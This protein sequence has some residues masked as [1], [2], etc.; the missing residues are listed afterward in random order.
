MKNVSLI[1]NVVLAVAVAV[2]FYFHFADCAKRNGSHTN[3]VADSASPGSFKIA[4]FDMDTLE[5]KY[6][7]LKE[8]RAT[9]HQKDEANTRVLT[10]MR[11][12]LA[13]KYQEYQQKGNSLTQAEAAGYE[14]ELGQLQNAFQGKQQE[15]AQEMQSESMRK[16]REVKLKIQSVLNDYSKEKGYIFVYS[17]DE[18]DYL[19]YK[20]ATRN[21]TTDLLK[22]LN[23]Q[24]LT[25]KKNKK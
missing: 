6:E 15:L 9:L 7:Y 21:I 17:S 16:L 5:N 8:V 18:N 25:E 1:I 10:Q 13:K 22:N 3:G 11:N 20:D 2:L 14:Q 4:Y 24:Y 19:Y 12:T 23:E